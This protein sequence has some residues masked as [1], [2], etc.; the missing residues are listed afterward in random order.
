MRKT[1][2]IFTAISLSL[3]SCSVEKE[4]KKIALFP[5]GE[6]LT[7]ENFTG[8]VWFTPLVDADSLNQN[9]VGNVIFERGARSNWHYHPAG[10][11]LIAT[12]GEGYYQEQGSPKRI[13]KKGDVVKCPPNVPHW[14][15]A[16]AKKPFYQIAITGRENGPTV[17]LDKVTDEEYSA[18]IR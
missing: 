7:S 17:W 13:L 11:I 6:R 5:K 16:S 18:A 3:L 10:Q 9:A 4:N 8:I 1:I 14:H 12:G 2:I 15:G